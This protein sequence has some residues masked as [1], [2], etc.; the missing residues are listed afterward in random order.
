LAIAVGQ[1]FPQTQFGRGDYTRSVA[2][3]EAAN[4]AFLANRFFS[5]F[6]LGFNLAWELDFWGRFRRAI[7]AASATLDASV[8]NYDDVLVTLLGEVATS[9]VQM[10]TFEQRIEYA[11]QNVKIQEKTLKI[12]E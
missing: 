12:A 2:S 11:E 10:R 8:E 6:D 3:T 5:Q 1:L 7:E 4:R 9:Y